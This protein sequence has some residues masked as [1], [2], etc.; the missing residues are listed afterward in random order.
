MHQPKEG[1]FF[2]RNIFQSSS[3]ANN[4]IIRLLVQARTDKACI[5]V[6]TRSFQLIWQSQ[7][8]RENEICTIQVRAGVKAVAIP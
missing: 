1:Y 5:M 6:L 8:V 4:I 3:S 7:K 2:H